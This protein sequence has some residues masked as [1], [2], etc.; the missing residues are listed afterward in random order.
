MN[1][2]WLFWKLKWYNPLSTWSQILFSGTAKINHLFEVGKKTT[3]PHQGYNTISHKTRR[4][5]DHSRQQNESGSKPH[6]GTSSSASNKNTTSKFTLIIRFMHGLK[7]ALLAIFQ[8]LAN[9][10]DRLCPAAFKNACWI[11]FVFYILISIYLL[12]YEIVV[13]SSASSFGDSDPDPSSV[14]NSINLCETL[15]YFRNSKTFF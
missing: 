1:D 4:T 15:I 5:H 11:F 6:S 10:L 8:K 14:T 7:S 9:C 12:K 2:P 13:R 3:K